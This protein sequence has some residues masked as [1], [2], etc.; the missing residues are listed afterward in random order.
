MDKVDHCQYIDLN[1]L[2]RLCSA[3]QYATSSVLQLAAMRLTVEMQHLHNVFSCER[4]HFDLRGIC[5]G[6]R[7]YGL[8]LKK[9]Q[10]TIANTNT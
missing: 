2:W 10:Q 7:L 5:G 3:T 8:A 1:A 9:N 6:I 4:S